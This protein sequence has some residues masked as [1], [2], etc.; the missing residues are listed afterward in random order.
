MRDFADVTGKVRPNSCWI[1]SF[2]VILVK[3]RT[4]Y[5]WSWKSGS[6]CKS[7]ENNKT[8]WDRHDSQL[9][10][11]VAMHDAVTHSATQ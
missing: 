10:L 11:I 7:D 9:T 4:N 6:K 8:D 2:M 5:V 3:H 1:S